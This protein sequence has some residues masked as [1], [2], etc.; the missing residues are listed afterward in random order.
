[1]RS[2]RVLY[3]TF[4]E[5]SGVP[6]RDVALPALAAKGWDVTVVARDSSRAVLQRVLPY[7]AR[8]VDLPSSSLA[9][10]AAAVRELVAGRFSNYDV[11][12]VGGQSSV[13]VA[14]PA[15][16]RA[17]SMVYHSTDYYD[18]T[19]YPV[20]CMF[21]KRLVRS[22][23]LHINA[24]LHRAYVVRALYGMR[25]P[26]LVVPPTLPRKWPTPCQSDAVREL[27][28]PRKDDFALALHGG[29]S[30]VRMCDELFEALSLLPD[31][32][33]LVMGHSGN[34]QGLV[35]ERLQK[36][37]L[38][39]RVV[40]RERMNFERMLDHSSNCDAGILLYRNTDAGNYF[41]APGRLTEY[42]TC[43]LPVIANDFVGLEH[44][45]LRYG[46]GESVDARKPALIA[47]GILRLEEHSRSHTKE[48]FRNIFSEVFAA[49]RWYP[50]ICAAFE[51]LADGRK[52]D[53]D[54]EIPHPWWSGLA[55]P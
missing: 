5:L 14:W 23:S 19:R 54:H 51:A 27:V 49:E 41:Q 31:R 50:A 21:E 48:H 40:F 1:M 46:L 17:R 25:C 3:V 24:E 11:I 28:A 52:S 29:Y 15:L 9:C 42:L 44:L 4:S 12:Y 32:F 37:G 7:P 34:R 43:G 10:A 39:G 26:I 2:R 53:L 45:T 55:Q 47:D 38:T 33:R 22:A 35:N 16:Y 6:Y 8:S 30:E 36:L 20:H 13:M 18:P